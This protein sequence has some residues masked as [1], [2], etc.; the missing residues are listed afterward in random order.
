MWW[1]EITPPRP[2]RNRGLAATRQ[3]RWPPAGLPVG[4]RARV[5]QRQVRDPPWP[6]RG[7]LG[8]R[9]SREGA[10]SMRADELVVLTKAEY[11]ELKARAEGGAGGTGELFNGEEMQAIRDQYEERIVVEQE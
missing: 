5:G 1:T 3:R 11:D 9:A 7:T 4:S 8:A 2:E 6:D 10:R